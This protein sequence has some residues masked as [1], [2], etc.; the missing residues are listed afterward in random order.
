MKRTKAVGIQY[1]ALP[2]RIRGRRLEILLI[3]SRE[4]RRWVIPKGWPIDRLK[5]Q[6]AAAIEAMEEA[7]L[8]GDIEAHPIGSYRY[9]KR[10]KRGKAIPIQVIVFPLS[11]GEQAETWKEQDQ[12]SVQWFPYLSA[13]ALVAEPNLK[14]LIREFGQARTPGLLRFTYQRLTGLMKRTPSGDPGLP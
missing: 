8:T 6:E 13:A 5:P 14:R 4:T 1:G 3:T 9:L 12:R 2:Y 10:M 7:G 11:V